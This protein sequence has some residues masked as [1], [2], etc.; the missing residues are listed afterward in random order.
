[1]NDEV[2]DIAA[3]DW[4]HVQPPEDDTKQG[5]S[6]EGRPPEPVIDEPDE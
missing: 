1:M 5:A 4:G 3:V 2:V 6:D